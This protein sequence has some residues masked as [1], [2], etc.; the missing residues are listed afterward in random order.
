MDGATG[1]KVMLEK[2]EAA[3]LGWG[4][5]VSTRNTGS[6]STRTTPT[7]PADQ[8]PVQRGRQGAGRLIDA[9]NVEFD[10]DQA[11]RISPP[12]PAAHL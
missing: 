2:H 11:G 7:K 9:Y 5:A 8:Q 3:W 6:P 10:M 12:D 4:A 1:F